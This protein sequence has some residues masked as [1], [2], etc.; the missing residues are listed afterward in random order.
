MPKLCSA[1]GCT[2]THHARG[3]C[4]THYSNLLR[5]KNAEIKLRPFEWHGKKYSSEYKAWENMH[6]RCSDTKARGYKN[7]GG[8]GIKVC[9]QWKRFSKFFSDMGTKP[10]PELT[11]DRIDNDKGYCK[12]N[13]RWATRKQQANNRRKSLSALDTLKV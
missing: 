3:W 13:C 9:E 5:H 7:Y 11:L 6:Q 12:D 2:H 10:S 1:K 8:R 4:V